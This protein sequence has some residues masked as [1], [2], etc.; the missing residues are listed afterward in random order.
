MKL[1]IL[2]FKVLPV[3]CFKMM[4]VFV[5]ENSADLN[6]WRIMRHFVSVFIV[7]QSIQN[8]K[9]LRYQLFELKEVDL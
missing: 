8:K 1:S 6:E 4:Y 2:Y 9:E 5:L 7:C 3:K